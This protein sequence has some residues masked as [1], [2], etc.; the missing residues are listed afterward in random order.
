MGRPGAR[1]PPRTSRRCP[2]KST[3]R[4]TARTQPVQAA[5]SAAARVLARYWL[6]R[7][8]NDEGRASGLSKLTVMY[9]VID[10]SRDQTLAAR[11]LCTHNFSSRPFL[12]RWRARCSLRMW[13]LDALSECGSRLNFRAFYF[14]SAIAYHGVSENMTTVKDRITI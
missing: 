9:T 11:T 2:T 3:A 4:S 12:R 7:P 8:C 13:E 6:T 1:P 14:C 10:D 5:R